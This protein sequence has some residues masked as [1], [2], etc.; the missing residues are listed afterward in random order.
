[1]SIGPIRLE[2]PQE[3]VT[4]E[5]AFSTVAHVHLIANAAADADADVAAVATAAAVV[6]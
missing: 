1:M 4:H 3:R 5:A 2:L 6:V